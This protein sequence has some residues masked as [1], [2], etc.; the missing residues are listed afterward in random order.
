VF[1]GSIPP[2]RAALRVAIGIALVLPVLAL[3]EPAHATPSIFPASGALFGAHVQPDAHTGPD[4]RSALESFETLVGREMAIE[5]VY[6]LWDQTWPTADD[7]WTRDAGRIPYISWNAHRTDGST[8]SWA[9]IASGTY[10]TTILERAAD[11]IAFGGPVIFSFHHEPEEGDPSDFI[12]AYRHIHDV[13]ET[14]QVTNVT[15]AWTMTASA[16]RNGKAPSFYPGDDVVDVVA[17]DGYN[18]YACRGRPNDPWRSFTNIFGAFHAFG[19]EHHKRMMIAEW[20]GHEDPASPG[21][22]ATWI[23]QA[24]TQ[25][26]LWPDIVGVLYY[27]ADNGCDRWVDSSPSSLASFRAMAADPYF[28]PPP[29]ITITSGPNVATTSRTATIAFS[30][31]GAAGYRCSLDG[32]SATACNSGSWSRSSIAAGDHVFEV[33]AVDSEG[34]PITAPTRW[35]WSIVHYSAIDVK[36]FAFSPNSRTPAQDTA[37][38][39]RFQGP[40]LHTV[41]DTSGMG[42]FDSGAM[43]AGTTQTVG[44]IGAGQYPFACTIHPSMTGVLKVGVLT[45]PSSGSTTTSFTIRWATAPTDGFVFDVQFKR[46]GTKTWKALATDAAAA[47][48]SFTPDRGAG[49]YSFRAR[50]QVAGGASTNWSARKTVSVS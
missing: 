16:F 6:Y 34:S 42:L 44:V 2:C 43:P 4:R 45:S 28:N 11:L 21:R 35:A 49:T 36:D 48:M 22:K 32:G 14:A 24:S 7:A 1:R 30:A 10:D 19:Q 41:T 9:Q 20:G 26:K 23:D 25:L 18:W 13:F 38:L 40:S 31:Q 17:S 33:S 39:F 8:A 50:T 5:R 46:P 47:S 37:V 12:A 27:D 29:S 3:P 15:Y